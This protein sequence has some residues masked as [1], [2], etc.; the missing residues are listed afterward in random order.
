MV[1]DDYIYE[2][3][4]SM[5]VPGNLLGYGYL[6]SAIRVY[7]ERICAGSRRLSFMDDIYAAVAVEHGANVA[8]VERSIRSAVEKAFSN[9]AST[10]VVEVLGAYVDLRSGKITNSEFISRAAR[11][12]FVRL[13][14]DN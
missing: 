12:I 4:D 6:F 13:N 2:L 8:N 14:R 5:R 10:V 11:R 7:Y 3:L 9:G 1:I